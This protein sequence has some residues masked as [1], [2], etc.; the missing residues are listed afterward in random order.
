[1]EGARLADCNLRNV[2]LNKA[3]LTYTQLVNVDLSYAVLYA[4][5]V[6]GIATWDVKL[7]NT[8][9][10][11]LRI[12]RKDRPYL[13][14]DRLELA[15]FIYL[16]IENVKLRD[17]LDTLSSKTVLI[18]GRFTKERIRYLDIVR[19]EIRKR[20]LIPLVFDFEPPSGKDLTGTVEVLARLAKF[21]V[22]DVSDPRSVPHELATVVPFLRKTP[23]LPLIDTRRETY[24]M[25][26]DMASYPWV[27][28][29]MEYGSEEDL[30]GL[31]PTALTK[32][33]KKAA[34]LQMSH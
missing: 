24:G 4:A 33:A 29:E 13:S 26:R 1:L 23:V 25:F 16:L 6:Y 9:Q 11:D 27:L 22:V 15:Q 3:N 19:D 7:D 17:V 20:S 32:A 31:C 5:Q 21:I 28:K 8:R 12:T 2:K 10:Q 14:V 34:N 18:L 30:R